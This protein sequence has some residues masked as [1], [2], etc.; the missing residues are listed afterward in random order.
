MKAEIDE[1]GRLVVTPETP[2]EVWAMKQWVRQAW[3]AQLDLTRATEG[4]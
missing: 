1:T 3:V 2:T 4:H